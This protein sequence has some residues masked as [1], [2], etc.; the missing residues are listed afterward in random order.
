MSAFIDETRLSLFILVGICSA[1][2]KVSF[3]FVLPPTRIRMP[4]MLG[5]VRIEVD[6][7]KSSETGRS[8]RALPQ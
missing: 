3:L 6:A 7:S 2:L 1:M 5:M 8:L 4:P